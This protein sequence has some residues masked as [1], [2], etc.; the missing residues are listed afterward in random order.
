MSYSLHP[1]WVWLFHPLYYKFI[2]SSLL[3]SAQ[4]VQG[5]HCP[6]TI[7][8][9]YRMQ[10]PKWYFAH[11]QNDLQGLTNPSFSHLPSIPQHLENGSE[12]QYSLYMLYIFLGKWNKKNHLPSQNV[13]LSR[14]AGQWI[15]QA[16]IWICISCAYFKVFWHL[17][18]SICFHGPKRKKNY[19][20]ILLSG[21]MI[22]S[23]R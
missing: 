16:L 18:Q 7:T 2:K 15:Y 8:G 19:R 9:Y 20:Y 14:A 5:F 23:E 21:A 22:F 1:L 4:S 17:M 11:V 3:W 13:D 10:R 12:L 6:L